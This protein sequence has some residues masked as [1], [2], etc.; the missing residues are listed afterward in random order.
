MARLLPRQPTSRSASIGGPVH[1]KSAPSRPPGLRNSHSAHQA[2][3]RRNQHRPPPSPSHYI[4]SPLP[5]AIPEPA[6]FGSCA[7]PGG[8]TRPAVAPQVL[9]YQ[10]PT[11][12]ARAHNPGDNSPTSDNPRYVTFHPS[13]S[14]G[15]SSLERPAPA[16]GGPRLGVR[17]PAPQPGVRRSDHGMRLAGRRRNSTAA[18][19]AAQSRVRNARISPSFAVP[20]HVKICHTPPYPATQ[21]RG[22][23]WHPLA[24]FDA[25]ARLYGVTVSRASGGSSP[26]IASGRRSPRDKP[27][28]NTGGITQPRAYRIEFSAH[29]RP[30]PRCSARAARLRRGASRRRG[31]RLPLL[32][33]ACRL[34]ASVGVM[35]W[36]PSPRPPE[37]APPS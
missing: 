32:D 27:Q 29:H 36:P 31:G 7:R 5:P 18:A 33:S 8:H 17:L 3:G 9:I 22:V 14:F 21:N 1:R 11:T 34:W 28:G 24:A 6:G 26:A 16:P 19:Q 12:P 4:P 25:A 20:L 10:C 35:A 23:L 37:P 15:R 2:A 13:P 30:P